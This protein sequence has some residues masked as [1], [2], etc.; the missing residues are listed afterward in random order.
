MISHLIHNIVVFARTHTLLTYGLSFILTGAEAFPVFGA[1]VPGTAVIIALG[2]LVPSGALHFWPLAAF[3]TAGAIAGDGLSYWLGHHYKEEA[4][5]RWPLRRYPKLIK[6]GDAFFE[7]HGGKAILIARFTPGVRAVVPLVA[8]IT[9]MAAARFYA[10]NILSALLW[11]PAHVVMGVL[12]GASLTIL[13]AVAGRLEALFLVFFVIVGLVVWLT[14]RAVRWLTKLMT[15]LRGPVMTWAGSRDTR[16][17]RQIASLL[18]PTRTELPGLA[19]L[20]ALL[21]ASLWLLFGVLQDLLAGDPLVEAD[22]AVL[23]LLL[24]LRVDWATQFAVVVGEL[25]SGIVILPVAGIALLWLDRQHAWRALAYGIA[26]VIGAILFSAGLDLTLQRPQPMYNQP[27]WSLFPFPGGHLA[28]VAALFGF[29]TVLMCRE[30]SMRSRIG[31]AMA[32]VF[33]IAALTFSRLYLGAEFLSTA[34]EGLGFGFAWSALLSLAYLARQAEA[35]RPVGLGVTT[36]LGL[37]LVGGTNIAFAHRSDM[38][39]YIL[40]IQTQ[41]MSVT[42]WRQSG[43][44]SLPARRLTLFGEF[45]QPFTVQWLG[46]VAVLKSELQARG[47]RLP[48]SWTPR[49]TLEF[50]SPHLH[51]ASL[52][53]L[54]RL[55]SGRAE[56]LV[57]IKVGTGIPKDKRLVFRLWRSDVQV[58][59]PDGSLTQL[60]IGT[61]TDE[62]TERMFSLL[63]IPEDSRN[64]NTPLRRLASDITCSR[65]VRRM[66]AG[67]SSFWDGSVLLGPFKPCGI[68]KPVKSPL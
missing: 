59:R 5:T 38:Q 20:G 60:W 6:Q 52:P 33:F 62:R 28:V 46:G 12:V 15:Q 19:V 48:V 41:T 18:D 7:K 64:M 39:H 31:V 22:R 68:L 23:H 36:A 32:T 34:L 25:G 30:L 56:G 1:L 51:P 47:W 17:R 8:G 66:K 24:S 44:A 27:G 3:A 9:G 21:I 58:S 29:L 53:V 14:P 37:V 13:G 42:E 4:V 16:F 67:K 40:K 63:N 50:L 45:D 54:P 61:I 26:S 55:D 65:V 35:V 57:M 11:A 10:L 43:W 49:S 2:A